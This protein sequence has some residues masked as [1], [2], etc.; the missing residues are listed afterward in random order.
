MTRTLAPPLDTAEVA[1]RL[2]LL[3]HPDR[4]RILALLRD[5]DRSFASIAAYFKMTD[6]GIAVHLRSLL[7]AGLIERVHVGGRGRY[8]YRI[9]PGAA[10]RILA[11]AA[12]LIGGA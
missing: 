5:D 6:A 4:L 7:L 12:A 8:R 2:K 1:D 3:A 10:N 9:V 11:R